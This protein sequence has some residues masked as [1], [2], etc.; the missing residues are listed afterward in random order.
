MSMYIILLLI[1][2]IHHFIFDCLYIYYY[3]LKRKRS[4]D[5]FFLSY[6]VHCTV[7]TVHG[8]QKPKG[9]LTLRNVESVCRCGVS[10]QHTVEQRK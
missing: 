1:Y 7:Y 2:E 8:W 10:V 6:T 3:C 5:Y 9:S 4:F